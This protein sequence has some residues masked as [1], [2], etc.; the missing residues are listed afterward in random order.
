[1][2]RRAAQS[3]RISLFACCTCRR[4]AEDESSWAGEPPKGREWTGGLVPW[5]NERPTVQVARLVPVGIA[6]VLGAAAAAA[7]ATATAAAAAGSGHLLVVV[8]GVR[9]PQPEGLP[10]HD[11]EAQRE[12]LLW[13]FQ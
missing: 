4:H 11:G 5:H 2:V 1:M 10:D 12:W 3:H 13:H 9:P 7:T 6:I 8:S